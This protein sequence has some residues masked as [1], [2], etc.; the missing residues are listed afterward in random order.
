M[1]SMAL[2]TTGC[3]GCGATLC[4]RLTQLS[5]PLAQAPGCQCPGVCKSGTHHTS[6][7]MMPAL[8][9]IKALCTSLLAHLL[10]RLISTPCLSVTLTGRLPDWI[11]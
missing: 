10:C 4:T 6:G 8:A 5:Q 1:Q 9:V 11:P 7:C 2:G 3:H